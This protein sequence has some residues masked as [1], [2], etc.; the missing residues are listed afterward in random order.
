MGLAGQINTMPWQSSCTVKS[1]HNLIGIPFGHQL[2]H[3]SATDSL[4]WPVHVNV[5]WSW[6]IFVCHWFDGKTRTRHNA[7]VKMCMATKRHKLPL[8]TKPSLSSLTCLAQQQKSNNKCRPYRHKNQRHDGAVGRVRCR[9]AGSHFLSLLLFC[10][11]L[12]SAV[13][14]PL[15]LSGGSIPSALAPL[16]SGTHRNKR[17]RRKLGSQRGGVTE[18][19][20]VPC[21]GEAVIRY[22][23]F[24][25]RH[26]RL[27]DWKVT[28]PHH[29]HY[30][31]N[32]TPPFKW[33]GAKWQGWLSLFYHGHTRLHARI[34]RGMHKV[35]HAKTNYFYTHFHTNSTSRCTAL[36]EGQCCNAALP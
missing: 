6:D 11:F 22:G 19:A 30:P 17:T 4:E 36:V 5:L 29:H 7:V 3:V 25:I 33:E 16:M 21:L 2:R 23:Y 20:R 24:Q 10:F 27:W 18:E 14:E 13:L 1:I 12:S 32:S 34:P 28:P 9:W 26:A 35:M 8:K 31:P 15:L